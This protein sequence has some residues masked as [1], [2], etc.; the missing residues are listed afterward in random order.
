MIFSHILGFTCLFDFL[1]AELT[2]LLTYVE[3]IV[4]KSQRLT[5]PTVE[6]RKLEVMVGNSVFLRFCW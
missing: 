3:I 4:L 1:T 5:E 2:F 6:Y